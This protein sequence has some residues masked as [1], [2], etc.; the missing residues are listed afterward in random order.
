MALHIEKGKE[1]E[2]LAVRYLE[3]NSYIVEFC[4]WRYKS[5]EIDIVATKGGVVHFIEVKT[6]HSNTFGFPEEAVSKKKFESLKKCR[7]RVPEQVSF[8]KEYSVRHIIY[9]TI[10]RKRRIFFV[11]R[12]VLLILCA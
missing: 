10:G 5:Y 3:K 9:Y 11:G 1:G 2:R 6:R 4:N 7:R 12:R 8:R